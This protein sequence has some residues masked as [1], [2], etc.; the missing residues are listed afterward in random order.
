MIRKPVAGVLVLLCA[1]TWAGCGE[2]GASRPTVKIDGSSTVEPISTMAAYRFKESHPG[3]SVQV[4]TSGTGGGFKKFLDRTPALRTDINDASRPIKPPE[5]EQAQSLGIEF[6]EIPIAL[7]GIAVM[8]HPSN[9]FVH[10]LTV[11]EL[12]RIFEPGS[13]IDNWEDVRAGFP[14][15]PLK[16]YGPGRDSGTFDYFTEA[17]VGKEKANRDDPIYSGNENDNVLVQG[18]AGDKG[19]LG[20]FGFSYYEAH[21]DKL[22][23]IAIDN[24]DGKPLKPTLENIRD[25]SYRPL[26]RPLFLYVS[27]ASLQRPVV[28]EFLNFYLDDAE[29]IVEHP[30]VK[31]VALSR[32]LYAAGKRRLDEGITGSAMTQA[33]PGEPVDLDSLYSAGATGPAATAPAGNGS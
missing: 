9:S 25:G 13:Q 16:L 33:R 8:V 4:G 26:S 6:I 20:Y 17:I 10:Y 5:I 24:G 28:K 27:Q 14:N 18:I 2:S 21:A 11:E 22:K 1:L 29:R 12:K 30:N 19:S 3:T 23:L 15:L 31:Y 32:D 7:D